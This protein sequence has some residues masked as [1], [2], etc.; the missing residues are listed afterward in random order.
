MFHFKCC[1]TEAEEYNGHEM[2][3]FI[4]ELYLFESL[5]YI[6]FGLVTGL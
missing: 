6:V 1:E 5:K 2:V 4:F 3:C